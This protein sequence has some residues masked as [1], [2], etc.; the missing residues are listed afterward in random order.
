MIRSMRIISYPLAPSSLHG[1]KG[2]IN[3]H[4]DGSKFGKYKMMQ[5]S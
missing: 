1:G 3:P 5:K 2:D 4:A